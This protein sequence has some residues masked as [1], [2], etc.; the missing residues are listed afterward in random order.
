MTSKGRRFRQGYGAMA[1]ST[2][3]SL[4]PGRAQEVT[5]RLAGT[6]K[7]P[8]GAVV[9]AAALTA[10]NVSTGMVTR[11]ASGA[12]GDYVFPQLAPGAYTVTV[13]KAGF[14]TGVM[15]GISLNVNQKAMID[16]VLQVGQVTQSVKVEGSAPLVDSTSASL[17]T[18]VDQQPI[19][20]LP[21]N[22]R[23]PTM[24]AL[25]VPGTVA[26]SGR[27]L[28]SANGNGSGVND[29]SYSGAGGRSTGNLILIDGMVSRA[30]NNGGVAGVAV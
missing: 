6:V 2:L 3:L 12:D 11:A 26:T 30:L 23:R 20:D 7:D 4:W 17:G 28:A 18:V 29:N 16:V 10:T 14:T 15:S 21:L 1:L 8:A 22:L 27:T 9:P 24:L 19:L 25:I 5:A 13:E